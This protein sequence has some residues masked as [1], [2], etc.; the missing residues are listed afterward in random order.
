MLLG[1]RCDAEQP[2]DRDTDRSD[3]SRHRV[4]PKQVGAVHREALNEHR[5][6]DG[7]HE[8]RGGDNGV[9]GRHSSDFMVPHGG[10]VNY[11]YRH[12]DQIQLQFVKMVIQLRLYR[13]H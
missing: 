10:Y 12:C 2:E 4:D 5:G 7:R 3:R 9:S 1:G 11:L 13:V 6:Q 8:H